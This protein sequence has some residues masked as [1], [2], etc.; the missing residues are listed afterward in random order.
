MPE[1]DLVEL[2]FRLYDGSDIGPF[3]YSPA[4]TVAMLKERIVA[5]WPK[6]QT[7]L[8]ALI[9]FLLPP[10]VIVFSN[11]I[12]YCKCCIAYSLFGCC[13]FVHFWFIRQVRGLSHPLCKCECIK[14]YLY[15]FYGT[16]KFKQ[17]KEITRKIKTIILILLIN[18]RRV[19]RIFIGMI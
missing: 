11:E 15:W 4:S 8:T 2:K 1:D 5:E 6:G 14:N 13:S 17:V 7:G 12:G 3:R 9:Q 18:N 10:K 16:Y 19:H